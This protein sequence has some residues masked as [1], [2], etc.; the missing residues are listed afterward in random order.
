MGA[1]FGTP[2]S[3]AMF[4]LKLALTRRDEGI[5]MGLLAHR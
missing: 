5:L 3:V 4:V 1:R 2:T